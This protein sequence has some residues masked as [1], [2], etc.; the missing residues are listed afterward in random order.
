MR[1]RCATS[2]MPSLGSRVVTL[3]GYDTSLIPRIDSPSA[4][5]HS[6]LAD[7]ELC[8]QG[9]ELAHDPNLAS[10]G[11]LSFLVVVWLQWSIYNRYR[12]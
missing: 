12:F 7:Y 11:S 8:R 4:F 5:A 1:T 6:A 10:F 2:G 3:A 9:Q